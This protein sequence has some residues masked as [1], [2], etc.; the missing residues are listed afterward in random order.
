M[1]NSTASTLTTPA[2]SGR[3]GLFSAENL[4]PYDVECSDPECL[5]CTGPETD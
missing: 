2:A 5:Y 1:S 3:M 4:G